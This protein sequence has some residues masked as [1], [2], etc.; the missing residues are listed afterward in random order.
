MA[1]QPACETR[2]LQYVVFCFNPCTQIETYS[3]VCKLD[4]VTTQRHTE[5]RSLCAA[6]WR[7]RPVVLALPLYCRLLYTFV[8]V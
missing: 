1:T 8:E 2:I 4:P 7:I 3:L 5:R 6:Y